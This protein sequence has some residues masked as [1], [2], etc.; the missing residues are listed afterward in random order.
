VLVPLPEGAHNIAWVFEKDSSDGP[1]TGADTG[2]VDGVTLH[3]A[4][5]NTP[6]A[7]PYEWL[8]P[9]YPD[10]AP[11]VSARW[12]GANNLAVWES[13]VAGLVPTNP[14]SV[15]HAGIR[16]TNGVPFVSWTP[17]LGTKRAY[18]LEGKTNLLDA[19]WVAPT[20][21]AT[22]FYRVKVRMP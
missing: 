7:V 2:W 19:A 10:V 20:N 6:V 4:S 1:N 13:Y 5:T 11:D 17:D 9:Y 14:A 3:R 15:F 16:F 8:D 21:S 22:R 18:A 12:T